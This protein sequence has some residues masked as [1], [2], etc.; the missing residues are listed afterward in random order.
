MACE[1]EATL[2]PCLDEC[3]R[4]DCK[5]GHDAEAVGPEQL[6]PVREK[7]TREEL[8]EIDRVYLGKIKEWTNSGV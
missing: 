5:N 6:E 8:N 4:C 1:L 3:V 7:M 2:C